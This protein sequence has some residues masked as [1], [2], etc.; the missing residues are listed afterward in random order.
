MTTIKVAFV[1]FCVVFSL[2]GCT[3]QKQREI[4]NNHL[5]IGV[6]YIENGQDNLALQELLVAE[7]KD[8]SNERVHYFKGVVYIN[9][10]MMPDAIES[11]KRAISEKSDYSQARTYLGSIYTNMGDYDK[12]ISQFKQAIANPLYEAPS[13]ALY[14]MAWA[15]FLKKDFEKAITANM[16]ALEKEPNSPL[17]AEIEACLGKIYFAIK[18][19]QSSK[20]HY[21]KS[22]TI[23]PENDE[24]L[25][26]LAEVCLKTDNI[27]TARTMLT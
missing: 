14:N 25:Y 9:K 23:K 24:S 2:W 26:G 1:V 19:Y 7:K 20:A 10:K 22:L 5:A 8:S 12:A 21:L 6:A 16:Q 4:A 13:V 27:E 15:Y 18:D 3:T 11:F 17:L